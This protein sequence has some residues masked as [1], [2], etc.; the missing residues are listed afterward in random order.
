MRTNALWP[1]ALV[2]VLAACERSE[3]LAPTDPA[4]QT[5]PDPWQILVAP[6]SDTDLLCPPGVSRHDCVV[7]RWEAYRHRIASV[8]PSIPVARELGEI[9]ICAPDNIE[10]GPWPRV[11]QR[12]RQWDWDTWHA[13]INPCT[14]PR[15]T[16]LAYVALWVPEAFDGDKPLSRNIYE[17]AMRLIEGIEDEQAAR[18][19]GKAPIAPA[20]AIARRERTTRDMQP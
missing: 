18:G 10:G 14:C 11:G 2:A 9:G 12:L 6:N 17:L 8:E 20:P 7:R 1:L 4:R 15:G 13:L 5:G 3:R 19:C 16:V